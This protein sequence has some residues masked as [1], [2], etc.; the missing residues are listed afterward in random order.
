MD[1]GLKEQYIMHGMFAIIKMQ[2]QEYQHRWAV[3]LQKDDNPETLE[4][5]MHGLCWPTIAHH[6]E[7]STE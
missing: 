4:Q 1:F 5:N 7:P 6:L 3:Y 2:E